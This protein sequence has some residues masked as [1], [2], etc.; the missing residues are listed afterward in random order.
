MNA[1]E[2]LLLALVGWSALGIVGVLLS[3]VR[4]EQ[5]KVKRALGWLVGIWSLYLTVLAATSLVQPRRSLTPGQDQCFGETCF[6]VTAV[7]ELPRFVGRGQTNDGSRLVR[8]KVRVT[9]LASDKAAADRWIKAYL[10][11]AQGRRWDQ[12]R[13]VSGNLLSGKLEPGGEMFS[14]PLFKVPADATGLQLIFTHGKW[15]R[16]VLRIGDPDSLLHRPT[17]VILGEASPGEKL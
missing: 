3:L 9:N 13:G 15:Q 16:G 1:Q 14:E 17:V 2:L 12:T 5:A 4:R 6:A 10:L 8:V 11:D 7:E